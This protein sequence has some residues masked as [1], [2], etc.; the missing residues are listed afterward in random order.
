MG[1]LE[2][3]FPAQERRLR[4]EATKL[5]GS[6]LGAGCTVGMV[7]PED[8]IQWRFTQLEKPWLVECPHSRL[9]P[10]TGKP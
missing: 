3:R 2:K 10:P 6:W 9:A 1:R 4:M 5:R 7:G 8:P